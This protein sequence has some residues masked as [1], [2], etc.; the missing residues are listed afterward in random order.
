MERGAGVPEPISATYTD[1]SM[2]S[3]GLGLQKPKDIGKTIEGKKKKSGH[4]FVTTILHMG[5]EIH[6]L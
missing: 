4:Y 6:F 3:N 5:W 2:I 1:L